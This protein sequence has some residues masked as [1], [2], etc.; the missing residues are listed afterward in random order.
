M[1]DLEER[2]R[3]AL[4]ARAETYT[5]SSDAYLKV[6]SRGRRVRLLR[7]AVLVP[8]AAAGTAIAVAV[9]LTGNGGG[10]GVA[11]GT[12]D[13]RPDMFQEVSAKYPPIGE[14]LTIEDPSE[15]RPVRLWF[16]KPGPEDRNTPYVFC[17]ISQF[18][19]GGSLSG[20]GGSRSHRDDE[21]A[22]YEGGSDSLWPRPETLMSYGA[23]RDAVAKVEAVTGDGTR[24]PGTIHRPEGAPLAIWAVTF[25][26]K[27]AVKRFEFSDAQGK[28]VQRVKLEA[29]SMTPEATAKPVGPTLDMP[30]GLTAHLVTT[31]DRTL[32]WSHDGDGVA[33]DFLEPRQFLADVDGKKLPVEVHLRGRLWFGVARPGT[34]RVSLIFKDGTSVTADTVPDPWG[35]TAVLFSGAYQRP[36]DVYLEG[37]QLVGYDDAGVEIWR[38]DNPAVTPLWQ[39]PQPT[40]SRR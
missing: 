30:G 12:V 33:M 26:S 4:D 6:Q 3:A 21:Q 16:A 9:N 23:A 31:P 34:A 18:A 36:G 14:P 37:F 17:K 2:L 35:G 15:K 22:W 25:P 29:S 8:V 27:A 28:V 7:W 40:P 38:D 11:T 19:P 24:I 13:E 10:G 1:N 5:V 39:T 20:C 32:I